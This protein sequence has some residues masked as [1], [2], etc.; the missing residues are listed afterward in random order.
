MIAGKQNTLWFEELDFPSLLNY[1]VETLKDGV[2]I[3]SQ[4]IDKDDAADGYDDVAGEMELR[5]VSIT[6]LTDAQGTYAF[7]IYSVNNN[8][9]SL[10]PLKIEGIEIDFLLPM[11]PRSGG[12]R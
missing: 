5:L 8:G 1:E 9:R 2:L 3:G 11:A 4:V 6:A 7:H 12:V 10:E